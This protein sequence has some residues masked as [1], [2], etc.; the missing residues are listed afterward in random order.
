MHGKWH[1]K[2]CPVCGEGVLSDSTRIRKAAY[3]GEEISEDQPGAYCNKCGDGIVYID[4]NS[5]TR[6]QLKKDGVDLAIREELAAI[7]QRLG[8]SQAQ[9][10]KISGGGHNAFSR[11][12]RGEAKPLLAV[13]N[14]WRLLGNF[15]QLVDQFSPAGKFDSVATPE[16]SN[17][18]VAVLPLAAMNQF[19]GL[20]DVD[21]V[22]AGSVRSHFQRF[23]PKCSPPFTKF[24]PD[25]I[26]VKEDVSNRSGIVRPQDVRIEVGRGKENARVSKRT[27]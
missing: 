8:L 13:V 5:E 10:A 22:F 14:L 12:E 1:G 17:P 4:E 7:R 21:L 23:E 2:T 27:H 20:F 11:Y 19:S 18:T 16:P 6:W 3:Q 15:P 26:D 9:A 24:H 25:S